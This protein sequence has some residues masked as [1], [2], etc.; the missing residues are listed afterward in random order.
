MT[1]KLCSPIVRPWHWLIVCLLGFMLQGV[2]APALWWVEI[3]TPI[4]AAGGFDRIFTVVLPPEA[5]AK[6]IQLT[7]QFGEP[8]PWQFD[9]DR[10]DRIVVRIPAKARIAQ[11]GKARLSIVAELPS[12]PKPFAFSTNDHR[13]A[14]FSRGKSWAGFQTFPGQVPRAEIKHIYARG[15]YL[16][17]LQTPSGRLVT[18][19]FAPNH[20]HHHGVWFSWTK[21]EFEGRHPDFWNMGDGKGTVEFKSLDVLT[22]ASVFAGFRSTQRYLDLMA[23]EPKAALDERWE[24]RFYDSNGES[25]FNVIDLRVRQTCSGS[26]PL[27]LPEYRYGGIG[28]RGNRA[29][30]GAAHARFLTSNGESDRVKAHATRVNWCYMGGDVDG[31]AAGIVVLA[32]AGNFRSPEP[33]RV[34]PTEPFL[35]FAPSQGGDFEIRPGQ[36]YEVRYRMLLVDGAPKAAQI[37]A[38][39]ADFVSTPI[40]PEPDQRR[41]RL[42]R[43]FRPPAFRGMAA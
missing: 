14:I 13:V 9:L 41:H 3:P 8:L 31:A 6:P 20:I 17:P 38:A 25:E 7:A 40:T 10:H 32:H 39:W 29:W 42:S 26:S 16:H 19:D 4:H 18:D 15:G 11:G 24:I 22:H 28:L 27:K 2:G 34:H 30:D 37:D 36:V 43:R 5:I 21:T 12:Q 1:Q 23:G 33:V 35:N